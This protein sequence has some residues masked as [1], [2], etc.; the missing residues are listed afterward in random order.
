[1]PG[2]YVE[3]LARHHVVVAVGACMRSLPEMT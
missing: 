3:R 1:M 2:P